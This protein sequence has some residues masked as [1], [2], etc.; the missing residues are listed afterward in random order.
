MSKSI[1]F[2]ILQKVVG[3]H[4]KRPEPAGIDDGWA[5]GSGLVAARR[6]PGGSGIPPPFI[7]RHF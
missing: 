5:A 4:W 1:G 2:I 3:N 7:I 6:H